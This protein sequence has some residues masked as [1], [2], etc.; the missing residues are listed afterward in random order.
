MPRMRATSGVMPE[1]DWE[2]GARLV[3]FWI[4]SSLRQGTY[5][6]VP[7]STFTT[8]RARSSTP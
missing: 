6:Q 4:S 3:V 1:W 2:I 5:L 7:L 8:T